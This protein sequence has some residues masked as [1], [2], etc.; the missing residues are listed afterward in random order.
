MIYSACMYS[1]LLT[2]LS[3]DCLTLQGLI[4]SLIRL[5]SLNFDFRLVSETLYTEMHV[6]ACWPTQY[7]ALMAGRREP[8]IYC[9][10]AY[11]IVDV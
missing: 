10:P 8:G 3:R 5:I 2:F 6:H 7:P 9:L 1:D 11:V 4:L